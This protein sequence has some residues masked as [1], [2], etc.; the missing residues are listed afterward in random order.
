MFEKKIKSFKKVICFM[1]SVF[2]CM[3]FLTTVSAENEEYY[4]KDGEN[5][6]TDNSTIEIE[7]RGLGAILV[8]VGQVLV[9]FI[10]DGAIVSTTGHSGGEWA[11]YG[12]NAAAEVAGGLWEGA[13]SLFMNTNTK[14]VDYAKNASGCI[15]TSPS[16]TIYYCS[17]R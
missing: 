11:S 5:Q 4:P 12:I 15:K 10:I 1:L 8:F 2:L 14:K 9:A 3:G 13:K 6:V 17:S 16:A 7:P